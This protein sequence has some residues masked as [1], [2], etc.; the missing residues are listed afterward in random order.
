MQ[1]RVFSE[2]FLKDG[3]P[4]PL[5]VIGKDAEES[6]NTIPNQRQLALVRFWEQQDA[7]LKNQQDGTADRATSITA[8]DM[9]SFAKTSPPASD[10][11]EFR[12]RFHN[13]NLPC[14]I[15]GLDTTPYFSSVCAKWRCALAGGAEHGTIPAR[16]KRA[17]NR[18]WFLEHVGKETKVPV[19]FQSSTS[20]VV[21][22]LDEDGRAEECET[23]EMSLHKWVDLLD[24]AIQD[25]P[26]L[27]YQQHGDYYLKDWHLQSKLSETS[28]LEA[29]SDDGI[30]YH[31]PPYFQHDLL[32]DFLTKFT[33]SGDYMFTYWGPEGSRT[34]LHS[35]VMNSF[36]WSFNV[37]GTKEWRF[38]PPRRSSQ[39]QKDLLQ[40]PI[41]LVQKAGE[42]IF[43]P[44]G[45]QHDVRNLE[46]TLSINHNWI[47][48]A[49][50]DL[51]WECMCLEQKAIETE[52]R[53]WG[54]GDEC[55]NAR[56][57]ML[58]GCLGLDVTAFFLMLLTRTLGLLLSA[59]HPATEVPVGAVGEGNLWQLHF[60]LA[61]LKQALLI[62]LGL[63][64]EGRAQDHNAR[65]ETSSEL[66]ERLAAV[67]GNRE[68]A[69]NAIRIAKW[70]TAAIGCCSLVD[71]SNSS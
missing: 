1:G 19:R 62:L 52:L 37:E 5:V 8:I 44:S 71:C 11:V 41:G 32:N 3:S 29:T 61:R 16:M 2:S 57:S 56:E 38:Y 17:I 49:N 24:E 10:S 6:A 64:V 43:V 14:L 59:V 53:A 18:N 25:G 63:R 48:T 23:K 27:C 68:A 26:Y 12:K 67:L 34:P 42:A 20:E 55:W 40:D 54:M 21:A 39:H 15:R 66:E 31:I 35:D 9:T 13:G 30:L 4:C 33:Q 50:I 58:R 45:W 47:T 51:T 36:S 7:W 22:G 28:G 60:D 69:I 65:I 46:E 70:A